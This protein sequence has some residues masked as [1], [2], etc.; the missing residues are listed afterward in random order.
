MSRLHTTVLLSNSVRHPLLD[1]CDKRWTKT[2]HSGASAGIHARGY[3]FTAISVLSALPTKTPC[4]NRRGAKGH[5]HWCL[6]FRNVQTLELIIRT[7]EI[8]PKNRKKKKIANQC[9]IPHSGKLI[10]VVMLEKIKLI[11][12]MVT[13]QPH[14]Q[15][16]VFFHESCFDYF[17]FKR[18]LP[19]WRRG[20]VDPRRTV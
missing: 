20:Q 8:F 1:P 19:T 18:H 17:Y 11:L 7:A 16:R 10:D 5:I 6:R 9:W 4:S 15:N 2:K 13:R 12:L 14:W 3:P